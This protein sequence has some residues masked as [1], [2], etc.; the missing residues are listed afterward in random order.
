MYTTQLN[1]TTQARLLKSWLKEDGGLVRA[2]SGYLNIL[3]ELQ[4]ERY[5]KNIIYPAML[6]LKKQLE[7]CSD[8][9]ER[10]ATIVSGFRIRALSRVDEDN[11]RIRKYR[12]SIEYKNIYFYNIINEISRTNINWS[13]RAGGSYLDR[14]NKMA[15]KLFKHGFIVGEVFTIKE[16]REVGILD[17]VLDK[18]RYTIKRLNRAEEWMNEYNPN[19][20]KNKSNFMSM[21]NDL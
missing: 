7:R 16:A 6:E 3:R 5:E 1:D 11:Q 4:E 20:I 19:P 21:L 15:E 14:E 13:I 18:L 9:G 2:H 10:L 17:D 8:E 12:F